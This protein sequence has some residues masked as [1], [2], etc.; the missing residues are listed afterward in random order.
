M[1]VL[2]VGY[3]SGGATKYPHIGGR[4]VPVAIAGTID[5]E[6]ITREMTSLIEAEAKQPA[7][8]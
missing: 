2:R 3:D 8:A 1:G 4:P 7:Q 6:A 5:R